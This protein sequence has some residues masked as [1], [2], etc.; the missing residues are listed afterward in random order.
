MKES[1]DMLC[2]SLILSLTCSLQSVFDHAADTGSRA[3]GAG[4]EGW[5]CSLA[6]RS[7]QIL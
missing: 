2:N 1:H 6:E 7:C 3:G 4:W 5:G